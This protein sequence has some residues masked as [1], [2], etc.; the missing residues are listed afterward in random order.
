ML[1]SEF[2]A[3][4][5]V[6]GNLSWG[7]VSGFFPRDKY[8]VEDRAQLDQMFD[9]DVQH[10]FM[11]RQWIK[12]EGLEFTCADGLWT[13]K[14]TH[15]IFDRSFVIFSD[16][17]EKLDT[18]MWNLGQHFRTRGS[19]TKHR[20]SD[21]TI[22]ITWSGKYERCPLSANTIQ[23]PY[24]LTRNMDQYRQIDIGRSVNFGFMNALKLFTAYK[25]L[26]GSPVIESA[27]APV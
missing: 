4:N 12:K 25:K 15:Q 6:D 7:V 3:L 14:G 13:Y 21:S 26:N 5:L 11:M 10:S 19:V 8:P 16:D 24:S 17:D 2:D 20:D 22:V 18:A 1:P 27:V 9:D 23:D